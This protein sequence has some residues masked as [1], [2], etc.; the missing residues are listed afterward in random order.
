MDVSDSL[1]QEI[2]DLYEEVKS[3]P[4][5]CECEECYRYEDRI[6][7][8]HWIYAPCPTLPA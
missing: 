4:R 6:R 8:R 7:E 3:H 2:D 1:D 5:S